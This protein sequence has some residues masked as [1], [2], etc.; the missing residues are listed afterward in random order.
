[1]KLGCWLWLRVGKDSQ[2]RYDLSHTQLQPYL[3]QE[4]ARGRAD[5][6]QLCMQ[7]NIDPVTAMQFITDMLNAAGNASKSDLAHAALDAI[8]P[9]LGSLLSAAEVHSGAHETVKDPFKAYIL[10]VLL[11]CAERGPCHQ[12]MLRAALDAFCCKPYWFMMALTDA[13]E[14]PNHPS[15]PGAIHFGFTALLE[16]SPDGCIFLV[17]PCVLACRACSC[18]A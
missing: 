13:L 8:V 16:P 11:H 3:R 14:Q 6:R 12:S 17:S 10:A 1:V 2:G 7:A 9:H 5:H 15:L 4:T 18:G